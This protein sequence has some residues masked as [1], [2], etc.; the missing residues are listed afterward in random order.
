MFT[1]IIWGISRLSGQFLKLTWNRTCQLGFFLWILAVCAILLANSLYFP[2]SIFAKTIASF[3]PTIIIKPLLIVITSILCVF[4]AL[5]AIRILQIIWQTKLWLKITIILGISVLIYFSYFNKP[6]KIT[7]LYSKQPNVII[8][9]IDAL[10]PD[11]VKYMPALSKFL[12]KSTTF[13]DSITPQPQTAPAWVSI[14]TGQYPKHHNVR[15]PFAEKPHISFPNSLEEI[16]RKKS[17]T[18]IFSTDGWRYFVINKNFDFTQLIGTSKEIKNFLLGSINDFPL[19]NLLVNTH[20]GSIL[21][22]YNYGNRETAWLYKPNSYLKLLQKNLNQ[23]QHRPVFLCIHLCLPHWPYIWDG[24]PKKTTTSIPL[25]KIYKADST[26]VDKQFSDLMK[27][28]K[29]HKL[30]DNSIVIVISDHGEGLFQPGD[31]LIA[32]KNYIKGQLSNPNIFKQMIAVPNKNNRLDIVYGHGHDVL[33]PSAINN[34]M[35]IRIYGHNF[36]QTKKIL[37]P[38]SLIDIKPTILDYLRLP[39]KDSD[40]I[41]LLPYMLNK[42]LTPK[43]NRIIFVESGY[44]PPAAKTEN[45]DSIKVLQQSMMMFR[46]SP[47]SNNILLNNKI[48]PQLLR[49]KQRAIYRGN[50]I[51][52]FYPTKNK[53][54]TILV[55]RV[56]KKWTDDLHSPFAQQ[57]PVYIMLKALQKFY[58][59]DLR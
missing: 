45:I 50:W 59:Q 27:I 58:G 26:R 41:S 4:C 48:L 54:N 2:F 35:A 21:F 32:K 14:L 24:M 22:P 51:L 33:S 42:N 23:I 55:N 29:Q 36:H 7:P 17:Y 18:T 37:T 52:A 20:I 44:T 38:T 13:I 46:I 15:F 57:S 49:N 30:L 25:T 1:L 31:R 34:L 6:K 5:A 16:L 56:T 12:S 47:H 39:D 9:G 19:S 53:T 8:I 11:H 43:K 10:R 3:L 28:L 40:G